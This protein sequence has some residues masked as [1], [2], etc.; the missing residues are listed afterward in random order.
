MEHE[1]ARYPESAGEIMVETVDELQR[2]GWFEDA[3]EL[4]GR[5]IADFP[6]MDS[7]FAR[8]HRIE[9]LWKLGRDG[10]AEEALAELWE[11]DEEALLAAE[12]VAEL[13]DSHGDP[14]RALQWSDRAFAGLL[15]PDVDPEEI[16]N[17]GDLVHAQWRAALRRRMG[18]AP[19]A[20]DRAAQRRD[21]AMEL[22]A[23][24]PTEDPGR[25][26]LAALGVV[27]SA[28]S[29]AYREE[30]D[31]V[32]LSHIVRADVADAHA[33]GLLTGFGDTEAL[34]PDTYFREVELNRRQMRR[35]TEFSRGRDIPL[36]M[37]E[38][39]AFADEQGV[40]TPTENIRSAAAAAKHSRGGDFPMWPPERNQPCW[41]A[42]DRK[43][44]KC[45]GR[46]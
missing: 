6:G 28:P 3:L 15:R 20:L 16:E 12:L 37:A 42:S 35:E 5:V 30:T 8:M 44:K 19:D 39:R 21:P 9:T 18:F 26:G 34:T 45:C 23:L 10:D 25:Q 17:L 46:P 1:V 33:A 43:Y 24:R 29:A 2:N 38:I 41:C 40:T 4:C 36:S 32:L 31:E 14:L 27:D 11:L 7:A 13:L 22:G